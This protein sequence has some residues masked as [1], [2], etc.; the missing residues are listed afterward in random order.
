MIETY[1]QNITVAA[2]TPIPLNNVALI[3]GCTV[4][5]EGTST[6]QF[7]KCGVYQVC[8]SCSA[9]ASA[10]GIISIG[11]QKDN[12]TQPQATSSVT[13][14]DATSIHPLSFVTLV[15]VPRNNSCCPCAS[16]TKINIVNSGIQATFDTIDVVVTKIV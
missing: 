2:S 10:E 15:Q 12:V 11:L 3:K 5:K 7:N 1:S 14:A 13:A 16:P 9:V 4:Q 6:L 8:V